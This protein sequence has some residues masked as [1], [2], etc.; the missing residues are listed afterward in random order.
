MNHRG[1]NRPRWFV[2]SGRVHDTAAR[3]SVNDRGTTVPR[4]CALGRDPEGLAA[5]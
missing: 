2:L 4:W 3:R 5:V 1:D